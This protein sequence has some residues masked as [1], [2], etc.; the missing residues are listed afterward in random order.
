MRV[1]LNECGDTAES[2]SG[3]GVCLKERWG[4][5]QTSCAMEVKVERGGVGGVV[6]GDEETRLGLL[7][8]HFRC[9]CECISVPLS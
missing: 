4:N 2:I 6:D 7:I 5:R 1:W 3:V 9:H 8:Y